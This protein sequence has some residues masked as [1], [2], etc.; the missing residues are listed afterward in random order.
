LRICKEGKI[1]QKK[2]ISMG[3]LL[4]LSIVLCFTGCSSQVKLPDNPIVFEISYDNDNPTIIWNN[5]EYIACGNFTGTKLIGKCLGYYKDYADDKIY[6]CQL[7]EQSE[8]DWLIDT[9]NLDNCNEGI[10]YKE[11]NVTLIPDE[12]K[13]YTEGWNESD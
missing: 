8:E 11:K 4:F 9:L 1:L 5:K 13:E 12:L 3:R 2:I 6:V 7:K 10:I